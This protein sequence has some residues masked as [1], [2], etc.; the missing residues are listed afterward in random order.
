MMII[1]KVEHTI[2]SIKLPAKSSCLVRIIEND[3]GSHIQGSTFIIKGQ[4][5]KIQ[6]AVNITASKKKR[7]V[8]APLLCHWRAVT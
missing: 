8:R 5:I 4:Q 2:A 1:V 7:D 3:N 6:A